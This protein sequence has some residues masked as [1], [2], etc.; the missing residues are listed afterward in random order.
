MYARGT[1]EAG[2]LAKE[3]LSKKGNKIANKE[4]KFWETRHY[5]GELTNLDQAEVYRRLVRL[6]EKINQARSKGDL[7]GV[8]EAMTRFN[9][10]GAIPVMG[11][12]AKASRTGLD[13]LKDA[14]YV[15][16]HHTPD[17]YTQWRKWGHKYYV[18]DLKKL[19]ISK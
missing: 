18:G 6:G 13:Y 17:Q 8:D 11:G 4:A 10:G 16:N 1:K 7:K 9:Y 2:K 12:R 14:V 19:K 15:K 3:F 5:K